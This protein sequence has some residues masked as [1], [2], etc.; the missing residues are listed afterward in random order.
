MHLKF[1]WLCLISFIMHYI[2]NWFKAIKVEQYY[3]WHLLPSELAKKIFAFQMKTWT[4]V[5][6]CKSSFTDDLQ[7]SETAVQAFISEIFILHQLFCNVV[8]N[9][10]S[11]SFV[12]YCIEGEVTL[13]YIVSFVTFRAN[14]LSRQSTQESDSETTV[15]AG[16]PIR[17]S[18]REFIIPIAVE[19][20]GYVTPRAGSLEPSDTASTTSTMT[21][22]SM[23]FGRA[24]RLK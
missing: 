4:N 5:V 18:P 2:N 20:G 10:S 15:S 16:E 14:S 19:G 21:N 17:K 23:K 6:E 13:W 8:L 11:T 7:D 12:K 3:R 1:T 9:F 22:R 24:R